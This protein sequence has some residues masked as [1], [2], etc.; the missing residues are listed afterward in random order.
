MTR[1]FCGLLYDAAFRGERCQ[2]QTRLAAAWRS[3]LDRP[4]QQRDLLLSRW[5]EHASLTRRSSSDLFRG[6]RCLRRLIADTSAAV[7]R[8]R[9][10]RRQSSRSFLG[11]LFCGL[12]AGRLC[13]CW[14]LLGLGGGVAFAD[15]EGAEHP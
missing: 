8:R 11:R 5:E 4:S 10:N 1:F 12:L 7:L 13:L 14:G 6:S 3:L 2:Q 9:S 15:G